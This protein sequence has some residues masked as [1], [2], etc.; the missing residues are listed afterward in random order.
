VFSLWF[1][2]RWYKPE[3]L[4]LSLG[5]ALCGG[6]VEYLHRDPASRRRRRK[7]KS[8]IWDSKIWSRVQPVASRYTD[9]AIPAPLVRCSD[10]VLWIHCLGQRNVQCHT[11]AWRFG[12]SHTRFNQPLFYF[13]FMFVSEPVSKWW[14]WWVG[15]NIVCL[16][17]TLTAN[18][19]CNSRVTLLFSIPK[20]RELHFAVNLDIHVKLHSHQTRKYFVQRSRCY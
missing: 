7:G 14:F 8:Q 16:S 1:V 6:G 2:L 11:E 15:T 4:K 17:G 5:H 9:Y 19:L 3:S 13:S 12:D 18:E 20:N 10:V